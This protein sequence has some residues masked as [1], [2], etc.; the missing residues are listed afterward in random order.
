MDPKRLNKYHTQKV[1]C[2]RFWPNLDRRSCDHVY[3]FIDSSVLL[4]FLL[5]KKAFDG[6]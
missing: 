3:V 6:A 4:M 5:I 2:L 1:G